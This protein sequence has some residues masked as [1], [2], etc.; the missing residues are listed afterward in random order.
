MTVGTWQYPLLLAGNVWWWYD[1]A[2]SCMR[3]RWGSKP[4]TE[5]DGVEA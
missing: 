5:D 1:T 4:D 3:K 2:R